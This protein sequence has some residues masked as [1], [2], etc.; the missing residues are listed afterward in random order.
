M[1][2]ASL[3]SGRSVSSIVRS[4]CETLE[5]RRLLSTSVS[6]SVL[7]VTGTTAADTFGFEISGGKLRVSDNGTTKTFSGINAI[8]VRGSGG[9]DR[10]RVLTRDVPAVTVASQPR[11]TDGVELDYASLSGAISATIG[12]PGSGNTGATISR[13]VTDRAPDTNLTLRGTA[14]ADTVYVYASFPADSEIDVVR[15]IYGNGGNDTLVDDVYSPI[16]RHRVLLDGGAGNDSLSTDEY[17]TSTV[18]GGSGDDVLSLNNFSRPAS[19]DLGSGTDTVNLSSKLNDLDAR[20]YLGVE[21]FDNVRYHVDGPAN[22]ARYTIFGFGSVTAGNGNDTFVVGDATDIG[23]LLAGF[24]Y[25]TLDFSN[26][27]GDLN[28]SSDNLANDTADGNTFNIGNGFDVILGGRGND[29]IR[30]SNDSAKPDLIRGNA[31][32]D[33]IYGQAGND[34]ILGGDGNDRLDGGAGNDTLF[35]ENNNDVLF[36]G[37]GNDSLSAGAGQDAL[38]GND[39]NDTLDGGAGTDY[40]EGNSGNDRFLVKDNAKDTLLG[41]SGTDSAVADA[42]DLL[43][44]VESRA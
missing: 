11:A 3:R 22:G 13:G 16:N 36:G 20:G 6:G 41:G 33:T 28:L 17:A 7:T 5:S 37:V 35:G 42:I 40:L 30:G 25:D 9:N 21:R 23:S 12:N 39:G 32:H 27:A 10:V 2:R 38:F 26:A 43:D 34:T 8:A 15:K 4:A 19:V 44:S 14:S 24:G 1:R 31:G 18:A 29:T